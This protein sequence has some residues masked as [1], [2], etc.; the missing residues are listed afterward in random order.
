MD[1]VDAGG[2]EETI[3]DA[4]P[5]PP[6]DVV[7]TDAAAENDDGTG[8]Q[9]ADDGATGESAASHPADAT[10][11]NGHDGS[12]GEASASVAPGQSAAAGASG[13]ASGGGIGG[14]ALSGE[15]QVDDLLRQLDRGAAGADGGEE[16]AEGGG[17]GEGGG[18]GGGAP[19]GAAKVRGG[20]GDLLRC[21]VHVQQQ[22]YQ[23]H[24][25]PIKS[26]SLAAA[27]AVLLV[28]TQHTRTCAPGLT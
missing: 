11:S 26:T 9:L 8:L 2:D 24:A 12:G 10:S 22:D 19:G 7:A 3:V 13:T 16:G 14:V 4:A 27:C 6:S 28:G 20:L 15:G 23:C 1:P 25:L 18:E 21:V 5:P 17:G